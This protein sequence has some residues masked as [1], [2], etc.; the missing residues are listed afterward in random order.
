MPSY[1]VTFHEKVYYTVEFDTDEEL[2]LSQWPANGEPEG[3][4]D[5]MNEHAS[6]DWVQGGEVEERYLD[7]I[8]LLDDEESRQ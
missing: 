7:E 2:D 6:M 4:F 8:E 5:A 1:S 3:W